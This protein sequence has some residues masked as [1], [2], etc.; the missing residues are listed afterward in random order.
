MRIG[1]GCPI[2]EQ[3]ERHPALRRRIARGNAFL[4]DNWRISR[5][6]TGAS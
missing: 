3:D 2:S 5:R 4:A 6:F 1:A